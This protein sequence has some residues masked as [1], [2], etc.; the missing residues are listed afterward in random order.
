MLS[1]RPL[2]FFLPETKERFEA[3]LREAEL[4]D[5][6]A[7]QLLSQQATEV[8]QERNRREAKRLRGQA[9][10]LRSFEG[11]QQLIYSLQQDE[12]QRIVSEGT[13]VYQWGPTYVPGARCWSWKSV[14]RFDGR[15]FVCR[16]SQKEV[17]ERR[18]HK[19]RFA[20]MDGHT[21]EED[22]TEPVRTGEFGPHVLN[23]VTEGL[24][25]LTPEELDEIEPFL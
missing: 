5:Q 15:L 20:G 10:Q 12:W 23:L 6:Q 19:K 16:W 13:R 22:V 14:V 3:Q 8:Q 18:T 24:S 4:L 1:Q 25:G 17:W 2:P 7:A 11:Q 9:E 21:F